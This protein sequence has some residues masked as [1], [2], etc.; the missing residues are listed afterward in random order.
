MPKLLPLLALALCL[1]LFLVAKTAPAG[2]WSAYQEAVASQPES[3]LGC[4]C[5]CLGCGC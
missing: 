4:G 5:R 3:L 2:D 1:G